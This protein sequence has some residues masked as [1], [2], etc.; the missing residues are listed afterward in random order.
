ML[1]KPYV[2]AC[3]ICKNKFITIPTE[4]RAEAEAIALTK[5]WSIGTVKAK[6]LHT[7][8]GCVAKAGGG[9]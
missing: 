7:C 2:M 1:A 4:D 3:D 9:G 5:G 8:P 6:D